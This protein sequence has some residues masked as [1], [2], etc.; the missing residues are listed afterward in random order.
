MINRLITILVVL[1]LLLPAYVRS[2]Q[3]A[4]GPAPTEEKG[5]FLLEDNR[6]LDSLLDQIK[7]SQSN[8]LISMYIFKTS[9]KK[10]SAAN[11]VKDALIKAAKRWVKVKVLLV[12]FGSTKVEILYMD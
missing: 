7:K 5:V 8:I 9:G 11:K 4:S 1:S 2:E 12:E 6:Y 3:Q 10:T